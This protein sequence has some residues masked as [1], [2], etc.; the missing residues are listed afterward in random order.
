LCPLREREPLKTESATMTDTKHQGTDT[1]TDSTLQA[2]MDGLFRLLPLAT[3]RLARRTG[4]NP[5]GLDS[6]DLRP[7]VASFVGIDRP[8]PKKNG[9]ESR[10][11]S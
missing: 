4:T 11:P 10:N 2:A 6:D 7:I 8:T 1:G 5:T 3:R 9:D